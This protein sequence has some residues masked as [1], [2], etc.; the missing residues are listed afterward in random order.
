M[1]N[2]FSPHIV[3]RVESDAREEPFT[4]R[5]S[6]RTSLVIWFVLANLGWF[7]VWELWQAAR[8]L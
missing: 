2:P 3:G 4:K 8:W 5:Y 7:A 6:L 1:H